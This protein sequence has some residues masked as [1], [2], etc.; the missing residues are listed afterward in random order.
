MALKAVLFD[1]D[2]TLLPMDQEVFIKAYFKGISAKAQPLGYEPGQLIS[3][4]W[5][6]TA[7]MVKNTGSMSNKEA[8]WTV[9]AHTYGDG[10]L[11]DVPVFDDYYVHEF[12]QVQK[13]CGF[14]PQAAELIRWL[15]DRHVRVVLATNPIFPRAATMERIRW[16]GLCA[17]D[18]EYI[19]SYENAS[20]CKPNPEYYRELLKKLDLDPENCLMVGNDVA[21]DMV[22]TRMGMAVFL[23]T[24][25][26]INSRGAD[27]RQY[28]QGDFAAMTD[29]VKAY[30]LDHGR[31]E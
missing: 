28:P 1:L 3:T 14:Q 8:F 7:A 27:I 11:K 18:F 9:F 24:D 13:L 4:I 19:T 31:N 29:Y 23:V 5:A 12:C 25:C 10:S 22:T 21:E 16:A 20:F 2:G 15:K 17:E 6:G 26:L 30:V